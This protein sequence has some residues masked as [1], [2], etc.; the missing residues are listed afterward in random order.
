MPQPDVNCDASILGSTAP[1]CG[2]IC[3]RAASP[4]GSTEKTAAFCLAP[5]IRGSG[6]WTQTRGYRFP[7]SAT[8]ARS[9][10]GAPAS[11]DPSTASG[12]RHCRRRSRLF[13]ES[14]VCLDARTGERIWHFPFVHH[15]MWDLDPPAAPIL[16]AR[17]YLDDNGPMKGATLL[18]HIAGEPQRTRLPVNIADVAAVLLEA[19]S[20]PDAE[21]LTEMST[22]NAD[23]K[24]PG[25]SVW[26]G[27]AADADTRRC[28]R[29]LQCRQRSRRG[30]FHRP[31]PSLLPLHRHAAS[32]IYTP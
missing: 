13:G 25:G 8:A 21:T 15:G 32:S 16:S 2:S 3:S 17:G 30:A 24:P 4:T 10:W 26:L 11:I 23:G 19:G 7:R 31:H 12:W 20:N 28:G 14:L 5:P 29:L 6:R 9:T 27:G 22:G 1:T 18:H